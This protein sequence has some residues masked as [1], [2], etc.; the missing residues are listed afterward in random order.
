M[1]SEGAAN[2]ATHATAVQKLIRPAP[3]YTD[4]TT[5][6]STAAPLRL[7]EASGGRGGCCSGSCEA[8]H[9]HTNTTE[10]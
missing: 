2:N 4:P 8:P 10:A 3:M 1:K 5:V 9:V 7:C 6:S